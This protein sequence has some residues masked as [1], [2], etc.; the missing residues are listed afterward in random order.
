M[1]WQL[2]YECGTARD[3]VDNAILSPRARQVTTK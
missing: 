2:D 3:A 1:D